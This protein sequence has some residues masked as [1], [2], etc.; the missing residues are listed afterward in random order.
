MDNSID[1]SIIELLTEQ[2]DR[3][4]KSGAIV[5]RINPGDYQEIGMFSDFN[6]QILQS[7]AYDDSS[8][9]DGM[10]VV[11]KP[12]FEDTHGFTAELIST[13]S[14]FAIDDN[15]SFFVP[16]EDEQFI[17]AIVS[18]LTNYEYDQDNI[19]VILLDKHNYFKFGNTGGLG[20]ST[21]Q[22][23]LND[24]YFSDQD[25][26]TDFRLLIDQSFDITNSYNEQGRT[27]LMHAARC[28]DKE[29]FNR[30]IECG[31]DPLQETT[32]GADVLS[33]AILGGNYEWIPALLMDYEFNL[34]K[35]FYSNILNEKIFDVFVQHG[36]DIN[37]QN[38][39]G[40]TVL[41]NELQNNVLNEDLIEKIFS[42]DQLDLFVKNNKGESAE[43]LIR[44]DKVL[45]FYEN[46]KL[47]KLIADEDSYNRVTL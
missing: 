25:T 20:I 31:A 7:I 27:Y 32:Y 19:A 9:Q 34:D 6:I 13:L 36:F 28:D 17:R 10:L 14:G 26:E 44:T 39:E 43:D 18:E 5:D 29:F 42:F 23:V 47:K 41:L 8:Y 38:N 46:F 35:P 11:I 45:S 37:L 4:L 21:E 15:L 30:M 2:A 1:D 33:E 22:W 24:A 12:G 16:V 40:N 3:G